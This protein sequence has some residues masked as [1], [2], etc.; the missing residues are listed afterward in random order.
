MCTIQTGSTILTEH[1]MIYQ[2]TTRYIS[3]INCQPRRQETLWKNWKFICKC[4]RCLDPLELGTHFRLLLI[5]TFYCY[6]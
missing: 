6:K 3:S 1:Y 5:A 4:K 2:I